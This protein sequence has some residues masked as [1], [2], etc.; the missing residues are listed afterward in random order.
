MISV[1]RRKTKITTNTGHLA[2]CAPLL[3]FVLHTLAAGHRP[4]TS[5][6]E[7][8]CWWLRYSK[9]SRL[10]LPFTGDPQTCS[11]GRLVKPRPRERAATQASKED[12]LPHVSNSS[13]GATG[14]AWATGLSNH[15]TQWGWGWGNAFNLQDAQGSEEPRHRNPEARV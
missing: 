13:S 10:G 1:L 4:G 11:P 12:G 8:P 15:G 3:P 9:G 5:G 6:T 14:S 2:T 7:G